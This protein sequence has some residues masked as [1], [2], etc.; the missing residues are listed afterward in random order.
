MIK[1][2]ADTTSGL[3]VDA[4]QKLG[5]PYLPQI[6]NFG[7]ESYRDD[8]EMDS[9]TF[10]KRLMTSSTLPK[11]A[12]PPPAL[13]M[14]IFQELTDAGHTVIVLTPSAKVSGTFRSAEVAA[15]DFPGKDI[16][17]VDTNIVASGLGD[18]VMVA[19]NLAQQGMDA[20]AIIKQVQTLAERWKVYFVVDTLEFLRRGGR[21]GGAAALVGGLLQVKPILTWDK[22]QITSFESQRTQKRAHARLRELVYAECPRSEHAHLAVMQGGAE[23][24]A[25]ELAEEFCANLGMA[26]VR[27][28]LLPPAI[29]THA[30]PGV[31]GVSFFTE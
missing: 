7:D 30:G 22:D 11:T 3:S 6:I 26:H 28:D 21:I 29:L 12:A 13:Y 31:L 5:I 27:V 1:I 14:P 4:A 15:Q 19:H 23:P 16:H 17:V 9:A 2:V 24:Q 25:K 10:L 18:L 20:N 8:T